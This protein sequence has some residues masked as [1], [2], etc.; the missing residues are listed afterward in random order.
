M[1]T[2]YIQYFHIISLISPIVS[3][4][5]STPII[6][7]I[8][9]VYN[10]EAYL[11]QCLDSIINQTLKNIEII[12]ANDGSTDNSLNIL[13]V[14][15]KKDDRII[16]VDQS[17]RGLGAARNAGLNISRG[18]YIGFVDSDD[19]IELDTYEKALKAM[20][21]NDV[22]L[23]CWG[24]RSVVD[25]K[26]VNRNILE[27]TKNYHKI[28]FTGKIP[29]DDNVLKNNM[30]VISC[31][32]LWKASILEDFNIRFP[33]GMKYEDE[34]FYYLYCLRAKSLFSLNE[35]L[36]NY[37][38]RENSIMDGVNRQKKDLLDCINISVFFRQ[39]LLQDNIFQEHEGLFIELF[40]RWFEIGL[41]RC[42]KETKIDYCRYAREKLGE[43][44]INNF[45]NPLLNCLDRG[46][47][48]YIIKNMKNGIPLREKKIY[49]FNIIPLLVIKYYASKVRVYLFGW[50]MLLKIKIKN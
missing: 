41:R 24:A 43:M 8:I 26:H 37:R 15:A 1:Y 42:G 32:K 49:L 48:G 12:C 25:G 13:E 10:T 20:E 40:A 44:A 50:I 7:I 46:E 29:L 2:I 45:S 34:P 6:S 30:V 38:L 47:F 27:A 36:Y 33:E 21:S 18:K 3:S 16:L 5:Q 35:Y 28:R 23:V 9:P 14:Y 39:K 19:W 11:T 4:K 31:N 17:N 22:D